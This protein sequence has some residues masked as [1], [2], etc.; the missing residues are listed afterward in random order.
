MGKRVNYIAVALT[1]NCNYNCFYCKETGESI[2]SV[3]KGT[4][5]FEELKKVLKIAYEEGLST[6]RL[7]GGEPTMVNYFQ[8]LIEYIMHLGKDTKI[9]LNTNGYKLKKFLDTIEFYKNRIDVMI[10]V[11]SL[12]EYVNGFHYPKYLSRNIEEL[13]KELIARGISTRFNIVVTKANYSEIKELIK[14]SI[15]LGVNVKLLDLI[16]RNEYLG[17]NTKVHDLDALTFGELIYQDFKELKSYLASESSRTQDRHYVSNGNGIPMSAYFFGNQWVQVKDS[18]R[19]ATYAKECTNCSYK[20]ICY[21]GVFS[22][23]LSVGEILNI[24]GCM[25]KDFYYILKGK[26]E[27]EIRSYFN[28]ILKMFDHTELKSMKN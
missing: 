5:D 23:I 22:P 4:W 15:D 17:N 1:T 28:E 9:R 24:S 14:K 2:N 3:S 26:T 11:D 6:F 20:S 16:V 27:T 8:E 18:S 10:S 7:T 12:N 19:G 21:E 13:A 25:N